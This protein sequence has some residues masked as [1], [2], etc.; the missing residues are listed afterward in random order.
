MSP[1]VSVILPYFNRA[2]VLCDAAMS[3]L[4]QT[5]ED[6]TL[7]LVNDGSTD[8]S[9]DI[10][11]GIED[12]RVVHIDCDANGGAARARNVGL[13]A[14]R[15]DLIAFMDSDD[16]WLPH[17]LDRQL[18]VFSADAEQLIGVVGCAWHQTPRGNRRAFAAGPFDRAQALAGVAGT[19]T[20]MLLVDFRVAARARFDASMPALEERAFLIDCLAGG[21]QL[22]VVT[23]PLAIVR[24][25]RSDHVARPGAAATGYEVMLSRYRAELDDPTESRFAYLA[26]R[27]YLIARRYSS[28]RP[29]VH[30]ALAQRR[31]RRTAHLLLGALFGAKGFAAASRLIGD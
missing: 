4:Q 27:D 28:A 29:L 9:R 13:D 10:A 12:A 11:R 31:M 25:G 20:P 5:H 2:D 15:T 22:A 16:L 17:K 21:A 24:R 14:S 7:Y 30:R 26:A 8:S 19:G 18:A 6:L 23:E 1:T 3:V